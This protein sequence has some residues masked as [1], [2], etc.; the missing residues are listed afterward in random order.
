[1]GF[2]L[3]ILYNWSCQLFEA[4]HVL[5]F[6]QAMLIKM[7]LRNA[8]RIAK[9]RMIG[10]HFYLIFKNITTPRNVRKRRSVWKLDISDK[11][12]ERYAKTT[13]N[14]VIY[15]IYRTCLK[16]SIIYRY[17]SDRYDISIDTK[18]PVIDIIEYRDSP[19]VFSLKFLIARYSYLMKIY[20]LPQCY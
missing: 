4:F 12:F 3:I 11:R 17:R 13:Y 18:I 9:T 15:E 2:Q 20:D 8:L 7:I 16:F 19:L 14:L 5:Y 10:N 1:M 6:V